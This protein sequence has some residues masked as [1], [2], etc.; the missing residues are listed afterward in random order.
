MR[1]KYLHNIIE[2]FCFEN[3]ELWRAREGGEGEKKGEMDRNAC[4]NV[5][6]TA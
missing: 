3:R 2:C 1:K 5:R 6:H 4:L